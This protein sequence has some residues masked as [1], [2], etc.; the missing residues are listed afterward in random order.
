[1][2]GISIIIPT[3]NRED[4]IAEAIQSVLDQKYEGELEI[5]I[6]DDGSTD[7]TLKIVQSFGNKVRMIKK[8][9]DCKSQGVSATRNR[10]LKAATQP[11]IAFLDSDDFYLPD[12]L[13]NSASVLEKNYN[14]G[15]VFC[16]TLEMKEENEKKLYRP[17][18]QRH[19]LKND[20][21][22]VVVSRK[23][24][25]QTDCILFR[26]YVFE[27]VGYFDESLSS[28]EDSDLWMRVS[29]IYKGMFVDHY[30]VAYRVV[31][32]GSQL[33]IDLNNEIIRQ[34]YLLVSE[35]ALERY[36]QL[37]LRDS[38]RVFSLR[39]RISNLKYH[40]AKIL[41]YLNSLLLISRYPFG[42][43]RKIPYLWIRLFVK[44]NN[45]EWHELLYYLTNETKSDA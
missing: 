23:N 40:K 41:H 1:M 30:G 25:I 19:I 28:S 44:D 13:N 31:H 27:N 18:T 35:R 33:T 37:G 45:N 24:I 10:G 16:R 36:Y 8:G 3:Y 17:W 2:Q 7:K 20:I 6:S 39:L 43:F 5:I 4:Y 29:E 12:C 38:F 11:Y 42:F 9:K 32:T 22:N 26:K 34:N 21:K 14:L 15:F